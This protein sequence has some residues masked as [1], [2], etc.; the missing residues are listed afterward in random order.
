M[1]DLVQIQK[2]CASSEIEQRWKRYFSKAFA[3]LVSLGPYVC[4]M[5]TIY[6]GDQGKH[7]PKCIA[8]S[9]AMK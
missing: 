2:I 3:F 6:G 1:L 9:L 4:Y 7:K 5:K 8:M